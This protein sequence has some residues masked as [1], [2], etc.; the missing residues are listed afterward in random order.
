MTYF[1]SSSWWAREATTLL[2][3]V[4]ILRISARN[5]R[6]PSVVFSSSLVP[7]ANM[8][9]ALTDESLS[10]LVKEKATAE[11]TL[12]PLNWKEK[13]LCSVLK[14]IKNQCQMRKMMKMDVIWKKCWWKKSS[15]ELGIAVMHA[16]EEVSPLAILVRRFVTE[17]CRQ[18][19]GQNWT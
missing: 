9:V 16:N 11:F 8:L 19:E 12:S 10:D 4:T 2:R 5:S 13:L 7:F 6:F 1:I 3:D 14:Q 15:R 18:E 17:K